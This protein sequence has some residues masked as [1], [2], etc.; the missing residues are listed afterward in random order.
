MNTPINNIVDEYEMRLDKTLTFNVENENYGVVFVS[1]GEDQNKPCCTAEPAEK[2]L[3]E[4][5][6]RAIT[7]PISA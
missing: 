1:V 4:A 5:E 7:T 6:K 3:T 2:E